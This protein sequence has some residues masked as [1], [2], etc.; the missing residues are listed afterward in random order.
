MDIFSHFHFVFHDPVICA[1]LTGWRWTDDF[2]INVCILSAIV[3][4]FTIPFGLIPFRLT[5]CE[6]VPF[7]R[8]L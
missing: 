2:L 5:K 1:V 8:K 7:G 4:V 3:N 6:K